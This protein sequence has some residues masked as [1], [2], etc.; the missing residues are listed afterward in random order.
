MK[1]KTPLALE[2]IHIQW[3]LA[4]D[5]NQYPTVE[6]TPTS[7]RKRWF[8]EMQEKL[9]NEVEISGSCAAC[10]QAVI[11]TPFTSIDPSAKVLK[12]RGRPAGAK[13]KNSMTRDKSAFE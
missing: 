2:D 7:P 6:D 13:N 8:C 5:V 10:L 12:K 9:Y 3:H 4:M 11:E 1:A